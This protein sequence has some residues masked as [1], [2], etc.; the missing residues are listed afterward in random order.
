[1]RWIDMIPKD[2]E[3]RGLDPNSV[4]INEEKFKDRTWWRGFVHSQ[5]ISGTT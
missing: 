1:M 2:I 4:V 5:P 3:K